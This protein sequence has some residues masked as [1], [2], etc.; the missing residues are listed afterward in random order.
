MTAGFG[1]INVTVQIRVLIGAID[2]L[3]E[4]SDRPG[5]FQLRKPSKAFVGSFDGDQRCRWSVATPIVGRI[6][7]IDAYRVRFAGQQ[8][9]HQCIGLMSLEL[10]ITVDHHPEVPGHADTV[11][12]HRPAEGR[13]VQSTCQSRVV[14]VHVGGPPSGGDRE[15]Q[16]RAFIARG[17]DGDHVDQHHLCCRSPSMEGLSRTAGFHRHRDHPAKI[18]YHPITP[19]SSTA[20]GQPHRQRC[21]PQSDSVRDF[22]PCARWALPCLS[23]NFCRQSRT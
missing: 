10:N 3:P 17:T 12:C 16:P 14:S 6:F 7:C 23:K 19:A 9:F 20:T 13:L 1:S 22:V 2:P 8:T 5:I 4:M 15:R 11:L 18:R 21:G